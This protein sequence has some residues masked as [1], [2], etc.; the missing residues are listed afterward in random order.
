MI[1]FH[2]QRN[3]LNNGP[4]NRKVSLL[5]D[6]YSETK[7]TWPHAVHPIAILWL[8]KLH[9]SRYRRFSKCP[10]R[11]WIAANP[12]FTPLSSSRRNA[13]APEDKIQLG[14]GNIVPVRKQVLIHLTGFS[15][16]KAESESDSLLVVFEWTH[17]VFL[18]FC[19]PYSLLRLL[20]KSL[21]EGHSLFIIQNISIYCYLQKR[22]KW[23]EFNLLDNSLVLQRAKY[24]SL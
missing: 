21:L 8:R 15:I 16:S 10:V 13:L 22:V 20:L 12:H 6:C 1:N 11:K 9:P 17:F 4:R 19:N 5:I 23:H 18:P 3:H 14:N 7:Q 24:W 2:T